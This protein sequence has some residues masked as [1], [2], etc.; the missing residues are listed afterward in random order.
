MV[1]TDSTFLSNA[2]SGIIPAFGVLLAGAVVNLIRNRRKMH[3]QLEQAAKD[4]AKADDSALAAR[5]AVLEAQ[6]ARV[7]TWLGGTT[8]YFGKP[9]KDGFMDTFP[10]WQKSV[11]S[12]LN[13][14]L[15][16]SH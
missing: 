8:D 5:V 6:A 13:Q 9:R 16:N 11:D 3:D 7:T 4:K 2:L 10:E 12:R 1:G 15:G 14:A